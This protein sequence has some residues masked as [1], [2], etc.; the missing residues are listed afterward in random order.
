VADAKAKMKKVMAWPMVLNGLGSDFNLLII[1]LP[2][3]AVLNPIM[4]PISGPNMAELSTSF[5]ENTL[6]KKKLIIRKVTKPAMVDAKKTS[7]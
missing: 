6:A 2:K 5:Q 7:K 4:F 3:R 1:G